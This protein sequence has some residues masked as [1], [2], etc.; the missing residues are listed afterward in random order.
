ML[1]RISHLFKSFWYISTFRKDPRELPSDGRT[2]G[3]VVLIYFLYLLIVD[4]L[5][6]LSHLPVIDLS[7]KTE[8]IPIL[9]LELLFEMVLIATSMFLVFSSTWILLV[10]NEQ[11]SQVYQTHMSIMGMSMIT[12][13]LVGLILL[14]FNLLLNENANELLQEQ[15]W[16]LA[17]PLLVP[18]FFIGIGFLVW[19]ITLIVYILSSALEKSKAKGCLLTFIWVCLVVLLH[20]F[21]FFPVA[22]LGALIGFV[23]W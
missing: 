16:A 7:I 3:L 23:T 9:F 1:L 10:F 21:I 17:I 5:L 6:N 19:F 13:T 11:R 22:I 20:V 8:L 12:S 18:G 14:P 2:F 4:N 15:N